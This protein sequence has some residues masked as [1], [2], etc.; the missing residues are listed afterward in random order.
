MKPIELEQ[1]LLRVEAGALDELTE[2]QVLTLA[3]HTDSDLRAAGRLA[4]AALPADPFSAWQAPLPTSTQWRGMEQQLAIPAHDVG[5]R[6]AH[7]PRGRVFRWGSTLAAIAACGM[8][9]FM[10]DMVSKPA[11]AERIN[12]QTDIE[13]ATLEVDENSSSMVIMPGAGDGGFTVIVVMESQPDGDAVEVPHGDLP[14][15][16]MS[17]D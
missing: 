6:G 10:F 9:A 17:M 14:I 16:E 5:S 12:L 11:Q 4:Q 15:V 2:S 3:E 13:I 7:G 8:A 1:L